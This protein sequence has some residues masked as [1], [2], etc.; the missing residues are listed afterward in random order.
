[1][2][3]LTQ[4]SSYRATPVPHVTQFAA[5]TSFYKK[6]A[7]KTVA[8]VSAL[9]ALLSAWASGSAQADS[10]VSPSPE[11]AAAQS[12]KNQQETEPA[13]ESYH[14]L[15]H[16]ASL[17]PGFDG[18]ALDLDLNLDASMHCILSSSGREAR[19][20]S[21][22]THFRFDL[23]PEQE[24]VSVMS[25]SRNG[26]ALYNLLI[27]SSHVAY[28]RWGMLTNAEPPKELD[29]NQV[30]IQSV[31]LEVLLMSL[32]NDEQQLLR[33]LSGQES[34][35]LNI[36]KERAELTVYSDQ[37]FIRPLFSVMFYEG[38][39]RQIIV[40]D[41]EWLQQAKVTDD[42]NYKGGRLKVTALV[43]SYTG[44]VSSVALNAVHDIVMPNLS[45]LGQV[46]EVG[47]NPDSLFPAPIEWQADLSSLPY[48]SITDSR[49]SIFRLSGSSDPRKIVDAIGGIFEM[50]A[51]HG[52]L[53][54]IAIDD[55]LVNEKLVK[56]WSDSSLSYGNHPQLSEYH[57][58]GLDDLLTRRIIVKASTL[59]PDARPLCIQYGTQ[60]WTIRYISDHG[61]TVLGGM[62]VGGVAKLGFDAYNEYQHTGRWPYKYA[63]EERDIFIQRASVAALRG[64]LSASA[65]FNLTKG[66]G[67]PSVV[68]GAVVGVGNS[69]FDSYQQGLLTRSNIGY[70]AIR[71]GAASTV[72]AAGS[73]IGAT[74]GSAMSLPLSQTTGAL[75]GSLAGHYLYSYVENNYD[76]LK[77]AFNKSFATIDDGFRYL[78]TNIF[79]QEPVGYW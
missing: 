39:H 16:S 33:R 59:P 48:A 18:V 77:R 1:M 4:L 44:S 46:G 63:V 38:A 53:P 35:L 79:D 52:S 60:N 43:E 29:H 6:R 11:Q 28:N 73:I 36:S 62:F 23:V 12:T 65:S 24:S 32:A 10:P 22:E 56:A 55:D 51:F 9:V 20:V 71:A 64:G 76:S 2:A 21:G 26:T 8:F 14:R 40:H 25:I 49:E 75:T 27:A 7:A 58:L 57:N 31:M 41:P 50:A 47:L 66:L 34:A 19:D 70:A 15:V 69:L 5:T 45:K 30:V 72:A 13:A 74:V 37:P 54:V 61:I 68:A 78:Q 67:V 17:F 3:K 42:E